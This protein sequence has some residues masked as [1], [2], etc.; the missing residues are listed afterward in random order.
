MPEGKVI[1]FASGEYPE[2]DGLEIGSSVKFQGEA[3]IQDLGEGALGLQIGSMT[4]ETEG[5]ADREMKRMKGEEKSAAYA[6]AEGDGD[7]F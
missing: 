5:L 2:L 7:D 4:F 3:T 1:E 6:G